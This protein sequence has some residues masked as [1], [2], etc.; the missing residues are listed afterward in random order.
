M[1]LALLLMCKEGLEHTFCL[2]VVRLNFCICV[3]S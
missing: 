1:G 2:A 3:G